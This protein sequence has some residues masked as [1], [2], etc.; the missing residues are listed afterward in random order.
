MRRIASLVVIGACLTG[1]SGVALAQAA[2]QRPPARPDPAPPTGVPQATMPKP[3]NACMTPPE[4]QAEAIV[5]AGIVLRAYAR[6]CARRGFDGSILQ[7]WMA[8]DAANAQSLREA[9]QMRDKA[10]ARNYPDNPYAGQQ[11]VDDALASRGLVTLAP[12][13]CMATAAVVDGLKSW[14]DFLVHA[15][16]T[17][18]GMG[19]SA[20]R[21]CRSGGPG[22]GRPRP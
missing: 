20:I 1:W 7:K 19:K 3:D 10:Y 12:S 21:T 17:E 22:S 14:D 8:F 16:R 18:L 5:R 15:K 6:E 11:V 13:E 2:G 9:V 4:L